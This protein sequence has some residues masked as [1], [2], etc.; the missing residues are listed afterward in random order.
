MK[1]YVLARPFPSQNPYSHLQY[2][3]VCVQIVSC[4]R[5]CS[6]FIRWSQLPAVL[7][8]ECKISFSN[9]ARGCGDGSVASCSDLGDS[10]PG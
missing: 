4:E 3:V 1:I 7:H 9:G 6:R 2:R 10:A 5:C 8:P